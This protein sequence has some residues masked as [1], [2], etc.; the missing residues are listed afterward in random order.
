MENK[1]EILVEMRGMVKVFGP[2]VALGGVDICL[3]RGEVLGLIGENGSGKSTVTSILAGM[4]P[5]DRGEMRFRGQ[6]W[7]PQSMHDALRRGI[8]MIVQ[9][10]GTVPGITVAENL[11]LC[12]TARF[13]G[14]QGRGLV[15]GRALRR[16]AQTALDDIGASHIRADAITGSLD[17]QDRKLV[18]VARVWLAHPEVMVVDETTTALS[19]RGRDIIGELMRRM[20]R[21]GRSVIF[22]SHDLDEIRELCDRLTV[23]RDGQIIRSFE[24]AE[25]DDDAIRQSMIGRRLEGSYYRSDYDGSHTGRPVL[26]LEHISLP[27]RLRDVSLTAHEGEILG[28]GGLSACGMHPLGQVMF[29]AQRPSTGRV[30]IRG[31]VITSPSAAMRAG[32][33]YAAKDRDVESLCTDAS[34]RDN[35]AIAGLSHLTD[36]LGFLHPR[37]ETRYVRGQV[38]FMQVKCHSPEQPVSELSGGNKQKVVFGKWIGR[39]SDV[40]ILDCPTRGIDIGVKQTMYRLLYKMKQ[41]GK[42]IVMISEELPELIGMS[43]RLL[44]LRNGRL[45]REFARSPELSDRDII[46]YMV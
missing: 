16:A 44:I 20:T 46:G 25:Y 35:I 13:C 18:E 7:H 8:G 33:G 22:I 5:A 19:Q 6:P 45:T 10:S 21:D 29:G 30:C 28:I 37:R 24:R 17:L 31:Q 23:L 3:R 15:N 4:Q 32:A 11:F 14:K 9:E 38:D 27:G 43:D 34:I 39:G 41:E 2:V 36:R 40:L 12:D 26:T 42:T 1:Q